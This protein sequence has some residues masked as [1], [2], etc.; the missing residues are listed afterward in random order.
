MKSYQ[1]ISIKDCGEALVAIPQDTFILETPHPYKKLGAPYE[2]IS[3]YVLRES[4]LKGLQQAQ[5]EL[6]KWQP[7]WQ[8]K[9]FDAYRP[10]AVQQFMVDYTFKSLCQQ[11]PNQSESAI[12]QQVSQFWAQPSNDPNTPP[13]HSTGAAIDITLV[14]EK[15]ET[16][17]LGGAIDE[18]S[19]RS[20]PDFYQDA[21][22]KSEQ[23]Y[24][25]RREL[26]RHIMFSADFRQHPKEWWHFSLGDQLWAWLKS[27]ET[28]NSN[29]VAYYG[30][31]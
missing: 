31:V 5:N 22:G 15:G 24:H 20:Y 29:I 18:I 6:Q 26:L 30:R 21:T 25:Q 10:I 4:V 11:Y 28:S 13:P 14:N 2:G 17:N 1:A 23:I 7:G 12:A 8:I 3:P 19:P 27:Q 16:L 9:V